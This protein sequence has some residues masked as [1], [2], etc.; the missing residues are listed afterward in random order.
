MPALSTVVVAGGDID[1]LLP[2]P[3]LLGLMLRRRGEGLMEGLF[4][5]EGAQTI[6]SGV[7]LPPVSSPPTISLA[8]NSVALSEC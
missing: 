1:E 4:G 3:E 5:S 7:K 8:T 6:C 2:A